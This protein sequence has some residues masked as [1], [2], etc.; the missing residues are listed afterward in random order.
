[1]L[2]WPVNFESSRFLQ[3]KLPVCRTQIHDRLVSNLYFQ[4]DQI[5]RLFSNICPI[6]SNIAKE[7]S[8]FAQILNKHSKSAKSGQIEY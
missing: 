2:A 3:E 6:A 1:M 8:K 5:G 7:G 4:C